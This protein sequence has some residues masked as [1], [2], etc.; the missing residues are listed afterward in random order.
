MGWLWHKLRG[1]QVVKY[2][3]I[4]P[5]HITPGGIAVYKQDAFRPPMAHR[6]CLTCERTWL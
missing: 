3:K 4:A 6:E 2:D 5:D 1:H